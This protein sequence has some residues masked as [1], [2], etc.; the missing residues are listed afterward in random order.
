MA[1]IVP[2]DGKWRAH[3]RR[4]GLS[5]S[6]VFARRQDAQRWARALEADYD[7]GRA[8]RAGLR[9]TLARVI[10]AYLEILGPAASETKRSILGT[11]REALGHLR[12]GELQ[13][14]AFIAHV[15]RRRRA[16]VSAFTAGCDL[17]YLATAL[18]YAGRSVAPAVDVEL[19]VAQLRAARDTLMHSRQIAASATDRDRRP[20]DAELAAIWGHCATA[21][22]LVPVW[23][24]VL[25]AIATAMRVGEI[26]RVAWEDFDPAARTILIRNRKDP[27]RKATNHQLIP[28]LRG[29]TAVLGEPVDPVE[30][31]ERQGARAGRVFPVRARYVSQRFAAICDELGIEDL[32]FHDL[33]HE[34]ISRLFEAGYEIQQVALVSGHRSW[35]SLKR[36]TNLKPTSLHREE[37]TAKPKEN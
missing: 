32:H 35:N 11:V 31:M 17:A 22:T 3:V 6:K 29:V 21:R 33:R 34:A 36:Y 7:E 1:S 14:S 26:T 5:R 25:F 10:D 30:V 8:S 20:T 16:G 37:T 19:A 15:T 28:L 27:K 24:L 9:V 2:H 23:D 12:L 18:R 13:P 4:P